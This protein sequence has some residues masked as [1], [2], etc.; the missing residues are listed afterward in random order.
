MGDIS[1]NENGDFLC[2]VV[3]DIV[4]YQFVLGEIFIFKQVGIWGRFNEQRLQFKMELL[5]WNNGSKV[6]LFF[7]CSELC[8]L[9]MR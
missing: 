4:N 2:L 9:G 1:F 6:V 7:C 8:F 3:Y 5:V